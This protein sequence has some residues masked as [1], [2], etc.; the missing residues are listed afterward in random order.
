MCVYSIFIYYS[1]SIFGETFINYQII[2]LIVKL[3]KCKINLCKNL[4]VFNNVK[5]V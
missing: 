2:I 1:V 4:S 3:K 5:Y